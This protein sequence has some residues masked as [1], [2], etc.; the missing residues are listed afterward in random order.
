[1]KTF[2]IKT[3]AHCCAVDITER[4][5]AALKEISALN[6]VCLIYVSHTTA[7]V[8]INEG[9]DKSVMDDLLE[10]LDTLVPWQGGYKHAEGNSAAH[11]KAV[12]AGESAQAIVDS[13]ELVL[14]T[15]QRVFLLEFDGPRTRT[16]RVQ[17]TG[18]RGA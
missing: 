4:I 2:Q 13:G 17:F 12:L 10:T 14:G 8:T 7:A 9:A 6:G 16:I 3:A 5:A 15:W 18:E 1:M 11:I